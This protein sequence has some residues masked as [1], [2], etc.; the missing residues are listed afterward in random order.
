MP[1]YSIYDGIHGLAPNIDA[2][3]IG[4]ISAFVAISLWIVIEVNVEIF[5][6]FKRRRGLYYWSLLILSWG[7]SLHSIG[8][9]LNWFEYEKT[10]WEV[11]ALINAIGWSMMV[12]AEGLVLYSRL[13]LVV[14]NRNILRFVLLMIIGTVL[15]V[16]IPN[17]IISIP[18]VSKDPTVSNYW[19]P[20]DSVETRIQQVAFLLEESIISGLY[21]WGATKMLKPNVNIKERRVMWDLIY[22]STSVIVMDIIV[23]VLAFTNIRLI[24]EP[25]QNL[26]YAFKLKFEFVVLSQLMAISAK[27]FAPG[28]NAKGR[29]FYG[30]SSSGTPKKA[31]LSDRS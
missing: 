19:S 22:V 15:F 30:P 29:Y 4:V 7:I 2:V 17:W 11:Y 21:I 28:P 25:L 5:R 1:N 16:Q 14:R 12:T 10:P 27:G 9:L 26:S 24:K 31:V 6:F 8:Y 23:I 3:H 13:H 20:R 18:A